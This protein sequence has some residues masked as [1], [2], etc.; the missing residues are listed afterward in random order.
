MAKTA[1]IS[2]SSGRVPPPPPPRIAPPRSQTV[3]PT[4]LTDREEKYFKAFCL[5]KNVK[6]AKSPRQASQFIEHFFKA[7]FAVERRK[8]QYIL[9]NYLM[10]DV[11]TRYQVR[12]AFLESENWQDYLLP[13]LSRANKVQGKASTDTMD[14]LNARDERQLFA[15]TV[16]IFVV[17][18]FH[19]LV[20]NEKKGSMSALLEDTIQRIAGKCGWSL[21]SRMIVS[22][23]LISFLKKIGNTITPFRNSLLDPCWA[24]LHDALGIYYEFFFYRPFRVISGG[25]PHRNRANRR[26]VFTPLSSKSKISVLGDRKSTPGINIDA[27]GVTDVII[28]EQVVDL[29]SRHLKVHQIDRRLSSEKHKL[30]Q[31]KRLIE[32]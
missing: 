2:S 24:N 3:N 8:W 11:L 23:I 29:L 7:L 13:C 10:M 17:L 27:T 12:E 28:I 26:S 16:N 21:E 14:S 25:S 19:N 9:Q 15:F 20:N 30:K 32:Q 31:E 4:P 1:F 5:G 22:V 6:S 18:F